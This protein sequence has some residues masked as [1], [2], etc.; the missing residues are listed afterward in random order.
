MDQQNHMA[1]NLS[2]RL[3]LRYLVIPSRSEP[4]LFFHVCKISYSAVPYAW[5]TSLYFVISQLLL[6]F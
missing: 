6:I 2:I 1:H 3:H 4:L 5:D